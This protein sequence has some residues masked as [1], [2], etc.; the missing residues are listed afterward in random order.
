MDQFQGIRSISLPVR[1]R[2]WGGR[3]AVRGVIMGGLMLGGRRRASAGAFG[4]AGVISFTNLGPIGTCRNRRSVCQVQRAP[5]KFG[6]T[7]CFTLALT[8]SRVATPGLSKSW[9]CSLR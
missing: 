8:H 9:I 1:R 5:P 7:F 6:G 3:V 2:S 4:A